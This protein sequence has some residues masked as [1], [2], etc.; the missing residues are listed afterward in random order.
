MHRVYLPIIGLLLAGCGLLWQHTSATTAALRQ[1][2]A[3][4]KS[5]TGALQRVLEREQ[6]DRA[7]LAARLAEDA[8]Q[9]RNLAAAQAALVEALKRNK[10]WSDTS[11]PLD[12]Q[13]ALG[14]GLRGPAG[15]V[16]HA[17]PS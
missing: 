3:A 6:A 5:L 10:T 2:E 16:Q 4:T 12:V 17:A 11:V 14:D 15:R 7:L 13:K 1:Q 9:A 8:V